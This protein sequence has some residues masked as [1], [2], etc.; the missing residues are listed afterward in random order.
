MA[1]GTLPCPPIQQ[2]RVGVG[3]VQQQSQQDC[4]RWKSP[5][6]SKRQLIAS[7]SCCSQRRLS[8]IMLF[9]TARRSAAGHTLDTRAR[10]V[11]VAMKGIRKTYA[12]PQGQAEA[13]KPALVRGVKPGIRPAGV[14]RIT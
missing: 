3:A 5:E 2:E 4:D 13:L 7:Q 1:S 8:L 11:R 10:E 12:A 6:G 9:A 14:N